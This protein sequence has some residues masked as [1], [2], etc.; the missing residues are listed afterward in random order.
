MTRLKPN[1]TETKRTEKGVCAGLI[2]TE[3]LESKG[4]LE[5]ASTGCFTSDGRNGGLREAGVVKAWIW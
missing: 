3:R 1:M 5:D 2:K 4:A